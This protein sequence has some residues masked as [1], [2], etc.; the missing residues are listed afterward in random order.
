LLNTSYIPNSI[1]IQACQKINRARRELS[2]SFV[3]DAH[4][5]PFK[6]SS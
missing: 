6:L 2:F 3:I 5:Q 1:W 4:D